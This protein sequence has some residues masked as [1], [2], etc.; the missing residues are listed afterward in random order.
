MITY[1]NRFGT[2]EDFYEIKDLRTPIYIHNKGCVSTWAKALSWANANA[3]KTT[4]HPE[5][6]S[7]IIILGCQRTDLEVESSMQ[8]LLDFKNKYFGQSYYMS[9]CLAK[10][11][12]IKNIHKCR[13]LG[14]F[15][16]YYQRIKIRQLVSHIST[17][18]LQK[19]DFSKYTPIIIGVGYRNDMG[20]PYQRVLSQE[21]E[22]F[23]YGYLIRKKFLA[24]AQISINP[25]IVADEP[26]NW[27]VEWWLTESLKLNTKLS[28][29][30][31]TPKNISDNSKLFLEAAKKEKLKTI[32][33]KLFSN[34]SE[35]LKDSG[36]SV[37]DVYR[38]FPIIDKLKFFGVNVFA[39][40][41]INYKDKLHDYTKLKDK[42]TELFWRP[43]WSGEWDGGAARKRL[44][45]YTTPGYRWE[46]SVE[47][48][49][50]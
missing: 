9:G 23:G 11:L 13:R 37:S 42:F 38:A 7:S 25:L 34:N 40:V 36:R 6:A 30:N 14:L 2:C 21:K 28:F 20:C 10:R 18:E 41:I 15:E 44:H 19:F 39:D 50:L 29:C 46:K 27:Q 22:V 8:T 48:N 33:I 17:Y 31:L 4:R 35:I 5:F 32:H 16:E 47:Y 12:D 43:W 1:S 45:I 26:E 24:A 3:I 49:G